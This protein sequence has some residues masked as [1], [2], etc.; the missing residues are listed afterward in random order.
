MGDFPTRM[1]GLLFNI[2]I[3]AAAVVVVDGDDDVQDARSHNF[4]SRYLSLS[5]LCPIRENLSINS[6]NKFY[7]MIQFRQ[8]L[9]C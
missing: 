9:T 3:P 1:S 5:A 2:S 7:F 4:Q 6:E 8:I